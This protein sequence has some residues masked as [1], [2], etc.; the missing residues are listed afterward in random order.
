MKAGYLGWV[1]MLSLFAVNILSNGLLINPVPE[2]ITSPKCFSLTVFPFISLGFITIQKL[3]GWQTVNLNILTSIAKLIWIEIGWEFKEH[4]L[5]RCLC[6][7]L[8]MDVLLP[9]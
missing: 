2:S 8:C 9:E 1:R 4:L 7:I 5:Y 3:L 6:V